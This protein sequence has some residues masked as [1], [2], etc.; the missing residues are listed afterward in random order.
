VTPTAIAEPAC[1]PEQITTVGKETSLGRPRLIAVRRP[2]DSIPRDTWEALADRNPRVT[3]FSRWAFQRAW[4]DAY[5][6]EAHDQTL[7]VVDPRTADPR[8]P[9]ADLVAIAPLMHRHEVEPSDALTRTRIRH[10]RETSLTPVP[11]TAKAVF[12]GASYH[13]DYATFLTDP[14]DAPAVADAVAEQLSEREGGAEL[15]WDVVDLRRLRCGDP[16][17]DG[18]AVALGRREA[19]CGW[20][21]N[22][23][24]E[25]VCP[26]LTLPDGIDFEG[27]LDTLSK[28]QR[29][30][31]RRKIRRAE[32]AGQ[33]ELTESRDPLADLPGFS[34]LHQ[35]RWGA[36]GLFP[37]T[38]GG[39]RSRLFLRRM[40]EEFGANGMLPLSLLS[41]DGRRI[42]AGLHFDDGQTL[43]FY[44]AGIDPDARA[45]SPGILLAAW[46]VK[47]AIALGRRRLDFLRGD[48]P[49]KYEWG[50]VDEPIQRIL[51][52]RT[53]Q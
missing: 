23:E 49:Y 30:E 6:S 24:R 18:L 25:D 12:M 16:V 9:G 28:K 11:P 40:F 22:V 32:A 48:E 17:A 4:W 1:P 35:K 34:E 15:P 8:K 31:I 41:V 45:L 46:Y 7:V 26:V 50:A 19:P 39:E 3:P 27:Y 44:N 36:E 38:P 13:A 43:F 20:T 14:A 33:I 29:H 21:L 37:P 47:A 2:F 51:V 53:G 10:G 42:A 52:R 5:A